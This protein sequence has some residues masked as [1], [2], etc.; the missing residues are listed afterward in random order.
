LN[1]A[2]KGAHGSAVI[3]RRTRVV[4]IFR[5]DVAITRLVVAVLLWQ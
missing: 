3:K 4:D 5:D 1:V 2:P